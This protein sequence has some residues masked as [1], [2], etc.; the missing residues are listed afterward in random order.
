MNTLIVNSTF[1]DWYKD[2]IQDTFFKYT[3]Q[4]VINNS[5]IIKVPIQESFESLLSFSST[6][7][8]HCMNKYKVYGDKFEVIS[9]L[10][11]NMFT[12][13]DNSSLSKYEDIYKFINDYNNSFGKPKLVVTKNQ[14]KNEFINYIC[15]SQNTYFAILKFIRICKI[16][17]SKPYNTDDLYMEPIKNPCY[18]F[19]INKLYQFSKTDIINLFYNA[20]VSSNYEFHSSPNFIK[21]PYI[22][23][24]FTY[25]IL[26]QLYIH[27]KNHTNIYNNVIESFFKSNFKL[28]DFISDNDTMLTI[29]NIKRFLNN[30]NS[31]SNAFNR[32]L[33]EMI[34]Y[35]N[36]NIFKKPKGLAYSDIFPKEI[37]F[38]AYKP[39]LYLYLL[40][41]YCSDQSKSYESFTKFKK[42]IIRFNKYS[43]KFG[44]SIIHLPNKTINNNYILPF[45]CKIPNEK[46]FTYET[47]YINFNNNNFTEEFIPPVVA[48]TLKRKTRDDDQDDSSDSNSDTETLD[49]IDNGS[50][51]DDLSEQD[52]ALEQNSQ[53]EDEEFHFR[54]IINSIIEADPV[55]LHRFNNSILATSGSISENYQIDQQEVNI[56]IIQ[57]D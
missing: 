45:K 37:L 13:Y 2:N 3:L 53:S 25:N 30:S 7:R 23:I 1:K 33:K 46:Y 29:L 54:N 11:E 4:H 21:N 19:H 39:Y 51:Y 12:T 47:K 5:F 50:N 38:Q 22:N 57:E 18:I 43:P 40:F 55:T 42:K 56:N 24:K 35:C 28:K 20:L 36:N 44:R 6:Y 27:Y 32:Y 10:Y 41:K 8:E 16:K 9:A 52:P 17:M 48:R 26:V 14:V 31:N 49:T 15:K 34:N